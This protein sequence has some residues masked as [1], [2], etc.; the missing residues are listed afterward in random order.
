VKLDSDM[1][2]FDS[3]LIIRCDGGTGAPSGLGIEMRSRRGLAVEGG[4]L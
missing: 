2:E 4:E 1:L 3:E